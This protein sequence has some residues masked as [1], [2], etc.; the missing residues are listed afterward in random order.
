LGG[1][2]DDDGVNTRAECLK[3]EGSG[4]AEER[5]WREKKTEERSLLTRWDRNQLLDQRARSF[6]A[7][8]PEGVA[9]NGKDSHR[10]HS[11]LDD[12]VDGR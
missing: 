8:G 11:P 9:V 6:R 3:I 1:G 2:A 10:V 12:T 7:W 5:G 4:T